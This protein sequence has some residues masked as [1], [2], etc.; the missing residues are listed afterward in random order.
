M[1][2]GLRNHVFPHPVLDLS[3]KALSG[4]GDPWTELPGEARGESVKA[5]AGLANHRAGLRSMSSPVSNTRKVYSSVKP[6]SRGS[7]LWSI[8]SKC[9]RCG[10]TRRGDDTEARNASALRGRPLPSLSPESL[11][12]GA[13][14]SPSARAGG[15]RSRRPSRWGRTVDMESGA[16]V[17]KNLAGHRK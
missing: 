17:L 15:S 8:E 3:L 16:G 11:R 4:F 5:A 9:A 13:R 12:V 10:P 7:S 14:S 2:H 6:N 1:S